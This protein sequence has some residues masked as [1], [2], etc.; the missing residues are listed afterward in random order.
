MRVNVSWW[1]GGRAVF[2]LLLVALGIRALTQGWDAGLPP[3]P[4]PDERQVIM[5]TERLDHWFGDPEFF[6]YG[7]LHFQAIRLVSFLSGNHPTWADLMRGGRLLSLVASLAAIVLGWWLAREAWGRSA[8]ILF[9]LLATWIPLHQQLSHYAT[10]EAHHGFWVMAALAAAFQLARQSSW[11]WAMAAGGAVGVSLAVKVSSL[12]LLLPLAVALAM[13]AARGPVRRAF[14]LAGV[15]VF[16]VVGFFW[17]AQPWAYAGARVPLR[18][19]GTALLVVALAHLSGWFSGRWARLFAI[20]AG[21]TLAVALVFSL[22]PFLEVGPALESSSAGVFDRANPAFLEGVGQQIAMVTGVADLPYVR[23]YAGTIAGLY[24]LRELSLWAC[25][26]ALMIAFLWGLWRAVI[27]LGR[28]FW[29]LVEGQWNDAWLLL[30]LLVVWVVPM[31]LRLATLEVK[32]IRYWEPLLLPMVLV[33]AWSL[34]RMRRR[35]A[36]WASAAAVLLTM[37]WGVAYLWAFA[38]PHPFGTASRWLR[39]ARD[40]SAV[41]AWEH[42]DE[43]LPWIAGPRLILESYNLPDDEAKI[44]DWV[45]QLGAADWVV[46]TSNRIRR[47]VLANPRRYPLTGRIYRLLLA[48]EAGFE[49]VATASRGPRLAGLRLPVQGAD[50]S[51]VNYEFPRVVLLRRVAELDVERLI[52]RAHETLP[53]L[54]GLDAADLEDLFVEP[55]ARVPRPPGAIRQW[56]DCAGWVAFFG[57]LG[58]VAWIL[59]LPLLGSWPDAG[60]GLALVTGWVGA[61]WLFWFGARLMGLP[62]GSTSATS[63][64]LVGM[65]IGVGVALV[66]RNTVLHVLRTRQRGLTGVVA[67]VV[68]IFAFFLFVRAFNPAIFWGEKPMDFSFFNAFVHSPAWPPGEPWMAGEPLHYYYFGEVLAA[69]PTLATG[70][71][72]AVAYNL[73]C[74]TVPA[75]AAAPLLGFALLVAR[76]GRRRWFFILPVTVLLVGNLAWPWLLGLARQARWFDLWWAT[77]RVVPGYAIDEYPLW[78]ALFADLHAHFI[79][80][81]VLIAALAWAWVATVVTGGRWWAAAGL[82]GVT[83]GVLAATNPWDVLLF[84][85]ACLLLL[86]AGPRRLRSS[87]RLVAAAVLSL[88]AVVPFLVEMFSWLRGAGVAGRP[89]VFLTRDDFAPWW[90]V[91]R[92]F[93]LFLLPLL[94]A[95]VVPIPRRPVVLSLLVAGGASLGFAF[96][97]T[98][99]ALALGLAVIFWSAARRAGDRWMAMA[100]TLAYCAVLGVAF[101][102]R[103]T[104]LD[105]MNTVFKIYDGV[106]L[107]LALALSLI[108]LRT[109]APYSKVVV[110]VFAPLLVIAAVNLPLGVVQGLVQP[111]ILSP[112]PT[113][114]GRAYLAA[115]PSDFF[116]VSMLRGAARPGD[117]VAEAAGPSYRR[118]TRIAMHTGLSTV[119]GWEWHLRQRGQDLQ[120]I[121][122]RFHDLAELYSGSNPEVR[123]AVLDRYEVD[124]VVVGDLERETYGLEA[125]DP[126]TGI[127]GVRRWAAR[128]GAILYRVLKPQAQ[129]R[130][131]LRRHVDGP[132]LLHSTLSCGPTSG[133]EDAAHRIV[134]AEIAVLAIVAARPNDI[135][136]ETR[137]CGVARFQKN[138]QVARVRVVQ[139]EGS[140]LSLGSDHLDHWFTLDA[141]VGERSRRSAQEVGPVGLVDNA[142][143][144]AS[145]EVEVD[146]GGSPSRHCGHR[147]RGG[148]GRSA[149]SVL[150]LYEADI[151]QGSIDEHLVVNLRQTVV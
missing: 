116:L 26:P 66:R 33:A 14:E 139:T 11:A 121:M 29:R 34:T 20:A 4:H 125:E 124:W 101:A 72:E 65:A 105:R 95:A 87:A 49:V 94:V 149:I 76:R 84:A 21:I 12:G 140:E 143:G 55:A 110:S 141:D 74:A 13:V 126:L 62:V 131:Q 104:I 15:A 22:A 114:D 136:V 56:A 5:V 78:T 112:R 119:V 17:I 99:A 24:P 118:F 46:L 40:E 83:V 96:G 106:W 115:S 7:S 47:T 9:L 10:V 19:L 97:S 39:M 127:P 109:R 36:L 98:A 122:A 1:N 85:A 42:W 38:E 58:I 54:D 70:A 91:L 144:L 123:R 69:F 80:L 68:A 151:G 45:E 103:F 137:G 37:L 113:L 6:A 52:R 75:L 44:R 129:P 48:G 102:E 25:G 77:S 63:V 150:D 134:P 92:H 148:D 93:G 107:L 86:T 111:R 128:D 35:A 30:L 81:P 88:V 31:G 59:L 18:A 142:F 117:V 133:Q 138:D 23:I 120:K 64:V 130:R 82:C 3:S 135:A 71:D 28:R 27:A 8:G 2:L 32:F 146:V 67:V 79:A 100:W 89:L 108:L 51:F 16:A 147:R 73:M 132:D 61:A 41:V 145:F 60:L 43:T 90:A 57:A 53:R 50:E